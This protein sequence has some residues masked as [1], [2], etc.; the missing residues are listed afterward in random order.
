MQK[1]SGKDDSRIKTKNRPN[2]QGLKGRFSAPSPHD[3][4]TFSAGSP[5][6]ECGKGMENVR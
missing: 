6:Y 5:L 3:F 2:T 1:R 4:R